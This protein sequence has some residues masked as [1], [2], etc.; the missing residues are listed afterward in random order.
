MQ[1]IIPREHLLSQV[2][3]DLG[4]WI[5]DFDP[6]SV[7]TSLAILEFATQCLASYEAHFARYDLSQG[8]FTILMYL[9][10]FPDKAWTPA[11]LAEAAGVRRATMT[12]L[13]GVLERAKW[14]RRTPHPNDGRSS[15]IHLTR[16]GRARLT[17][18]LPDHFSRVAKAM[19]GLEADEHR[20]LL[21]LMQKFGE[22]VGSLTST[23][24]SSQTTSKSF[25]TED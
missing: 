25:D 15:V 23:D 8:R 17:N 10:H 21:Q 14:I 24:G 12:G 11:S 4:E 5:P 6:E 16:G 13:L 2:L 1:T 22:H 20:N 9:F 19:V 3:H 7:V 18:M